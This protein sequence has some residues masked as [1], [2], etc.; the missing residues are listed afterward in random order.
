MLLDTVEHI[1]SNFY[2]S[3]PLIRDIYKEVIDK[4][5]KHNEMD[6]ELYCYCKK[7]LEDKLKS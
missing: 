7:L 3:R 4:V 6:L 5:A 2:F 1:I